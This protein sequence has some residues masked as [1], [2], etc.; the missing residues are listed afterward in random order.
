VREPGLTVGEVARAAGTTVRALHHYDEI[1][2]VR[3]SGRTAAGYRLYQDV[4]LQRLQQVLAYRALGFGL[5]EIGELLAGGDTLEHLRRQHRLLSR[6]VVTTQKMIETLELTMDAHEQGIRLTPAELLE[7]FGEHDPTE[8]AE[9]VQERWG[10]TEPY[11]ESRRR[12][13]RYGKQDWLQIKQE[14]QDVERRF[15]ELLRAGEPVTGERAVAAAR[16]H[17]DHISR[18]FYQVSP[19][20]HVNL[21]DLYEADPRFTQHYEGVAAGLAGY[22]AGAIRA[23]AQRE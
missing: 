22:V 11:E 1:G 16:A 18:W 2:L 4:D 21:A 10:G 5:E 7:V 6:R 15:A 14:M 20:M 12:S 19:Q 13:A 23:A 8:H 17:R 3:P 9:Q